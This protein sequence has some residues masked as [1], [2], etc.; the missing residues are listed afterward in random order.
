M[1]PMVMALS[2]TLNAGKYRC[3]GGNPENP[4]RNRAMRSITLIAPLGIQAM[5]E[6]TIFCPDA[7]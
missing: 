4:P 5:A 7:I 1:A 2:A 6:Q 3:R